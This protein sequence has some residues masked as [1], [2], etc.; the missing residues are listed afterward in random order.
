MMRI[1]DLKLIFN[2]IKNRKRFLKASNK[3]NKYFDKIHIG[4]LLA[5]G[6]YDYDKI[7]MRKLS[8]ILRERNQ[9]YQDAMDDI[10]EEAIK[11]HD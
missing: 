1:T 11:R 7:K 5:K 2:L 10:C 8:D 4:Q 6:S 3:L 9:D